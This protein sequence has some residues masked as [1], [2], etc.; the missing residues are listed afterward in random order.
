M[1]KIL[2]IAGN[3]LRALFCSPV[4][5]FILVIFA[6]QS[7]MTFTDLFRS[8]LRQQFMGEPIEYSITTAL[9]TG[10]SGT[11]TV[12]QQYL[13]LYVPLLT[14]G[15]MSRE[16]GS[17]SIKLLYS[18][19]VTDHLGKIPFYD[20]LRVDIDGRVAGSGSFCL[21]HGGII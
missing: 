3:E 2:K 11:F 8:V 12:I 1:R 7:G 18:S 21:L 16:F 19:P 14:M 17:G 20:G 15:L 10:M 5:W 4:A 6:V 9:L 13:Y